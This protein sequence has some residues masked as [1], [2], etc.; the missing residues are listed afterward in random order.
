[1]LKSISKEKIIGSHLAIVAL[2]MF[3]L[4]CQMG[5]YKQPP[6]QFDPKNFNPYKG[7]V[8]DLV[9]KRVNQ[10]ETKG[11]KKI[12]Y[13]GAVEAVEAD[14]VEDCYACSHEW[15]TLNVKIINFATAEEAEREI[16]KIAAENKTGF[17]SLKPNK[18]GDETVGKKIEL[19]RYER[20]TETLQRKKDYIYWTNGSL[21]CVARSRVHPSNASRFQE[22]VSY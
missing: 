21:F 10:F 20:E 3:A 6:R 2:I 8:A 1:M 5:S 17:G 16:Q 13:P 18:M 15:D 11:A 14:Y 9:T 22:S 12:E 7:S 4:A 19:T